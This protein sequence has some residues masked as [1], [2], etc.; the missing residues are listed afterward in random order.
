MKIADL[1]GKTVQYLTVLEQDGKES[2]GHSIWKCICVCGK[3]KRIRGSRLLQGQVKSC[4]CKTER[5]KKKYK[6]LNGVKFGRWTALEFRGKGVGRRQCGWLCRCECGKEKI[7]DTGLLKDGISRSCGCLKRDTDLKRRLAPG[8]ANRNARWNSYQ[9]SAKKRKL[10][11]EITGDEFDRLTA[12]TCFYCGQMPSNLTRM[13]RTY[14]DFK[15]SGLDRKDSSVG[16]IS[17]NVVP[18][19][20]ICNRAK[21]DLPFSVFLE[22]INRLQ[23]NPRELAA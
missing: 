22:W 11:W 16:Y 23:N 10:V 4:G 17:S 20:F 6:D 21:T 19:C 18:C 8:R 7:V 15:Y 13:G 1:T 12:L 9:T 2:T 3:V 5:I 14:G